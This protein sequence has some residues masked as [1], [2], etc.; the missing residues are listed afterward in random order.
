M[1]KKQLYTKE[2]LDRAIDYALHVGDSELAELYGVKKTLETIIK[3]LQD[4][5]NDVCGK[6]AVRE[7]YGEKFKKSEDGTYYLDI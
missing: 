7:M 5:Y 6:I 3:S 1:G 2:Q 4:S